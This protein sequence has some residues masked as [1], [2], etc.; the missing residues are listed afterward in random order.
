MVHE[1][2][3]SRQAMR[4]GGWC[5]YAGGAVITLQVLLAPKHSNMNIGSWSWAG[6]LG[7]LL[8]MA[9]FVGVGTFLRIAAK[10]AL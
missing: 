7:Y 9:I 1:A 2:L 6:W 8:L 5:M 10:K 4:F 3:E